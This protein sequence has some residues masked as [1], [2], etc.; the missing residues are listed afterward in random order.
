[1]WRHFKR[2]HFEQPEAPRTCFGRIKL[3]DAKLRPVGV[4]GGIDQY[5]AKNTVHQPRR[6]ISTLGN[7]PERNFQFVNLVVARLVNTRGLARR[8]YKHAAEQIRK[9][10]MIVPISDQA[11]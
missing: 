8:P 11:A 7:L 3:V 6:A 5:I 10:W 2:A 1:M 9:R 4:A